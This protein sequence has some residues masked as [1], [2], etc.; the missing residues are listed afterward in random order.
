MATRAPRIDWSAMIFALEA[1]GLSQRD[2]AARCA[3]STHAWTNR[4]KNLPGTQPSF[5]DG[6]M[7]LA[8]WGE[9]LPGQPP[10]TG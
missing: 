7:L 8:L 6:A 4:L 1:A 5:H 3:V 9:T 2:I 10:P